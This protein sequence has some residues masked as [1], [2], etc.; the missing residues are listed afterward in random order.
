MWYHKDKQTSACP[1]C[2]Y[3]GNELKEHMLSHKRED[4][5][6]TSNAKFEAHM[7]TG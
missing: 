1:E 5:T 6:C 3:R 7:H 4:Y 2:D